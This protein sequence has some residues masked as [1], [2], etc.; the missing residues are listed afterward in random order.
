MMSASHDDPR[1]KVAL[2]D[3]RL[4]DGQR[5]VEQS[6]V[7]IDGELISTDASGARVIDADGAIL[8]PG[9]IDAHVH[10]LAEQELQA[11]AQF[12]VTTALDMAAWPPSAIDSLR[13][14]H[15][16]TDIRSAGIPAT[17][18]GS[19][20]SHIPAFPK[21]GLVDSASAAAKFVADRVNEGVDYIKLVADTPGPDQDT[22]NALVE[23]AKNHQM[24]TVAHAANVDAIEMALEADTDIITHAPLDTVL[25]DAAVARFIEQGCVSVPT[26]TMMQGIAEQISAML[27]VE[28]GSVPGAPS[29]QAARDSVTKLYRAGVPI[30]AGTDANAHEGVPFSPPHGSSF[31]D[32]LALLVEAGL[33]T[34]DALRAATVLPARYFRLSDR[35]VIEPGRRA[36]LVLLDGDPLTD[37]TATRRIQHVWCAGVEVP[38]ARAEHVNA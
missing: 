28:P 36:D 35:G 6:T 37:I 38:I 21:E 4:F 7:V 12:G 8:L 2:K 30:I 33:S 34:V 15:G 13:N 16:V 26:L 10:L 3:V 23:A 18:S 14:K 29:Y 32:E 27:G 31:H 5:L 17:C 20:H 1:E 22:L 9:F 25:S 19:T 11:L 24:L